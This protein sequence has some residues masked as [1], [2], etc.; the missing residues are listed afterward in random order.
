MFVENTVKFTKGKKAITASCVEKILKTTGTKISYK[1][2]A[3]LNI[4]RFLSRVSW[5]LFILLSFI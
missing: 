1:F 3:E 2:C 5:D 4:E